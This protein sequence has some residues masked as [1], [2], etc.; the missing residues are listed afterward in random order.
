MRDH[1]VTKHSSTLAKDQEEKRIKKKKGGGK[2]EGGITHRLTRRHRRSTIQKPLV[3]K[4]VAQIVIKVSSLAP[5]VRNPSFG[6]PAMI[7]AAEREI[8]SVGGAVV[9]ETIVAHERWEVGARVGCAGLDDVF[10]VRKEG[11]DLIAG[12]GVEDCPGEGVGED[13][14]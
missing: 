13:G 11:E 3:D 14:S 5:F 1:L 2:K 7:V 10:F 4:L 9:A 6:E 12:L 8:G